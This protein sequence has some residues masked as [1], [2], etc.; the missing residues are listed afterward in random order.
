MDCQQRYDTLNIKSNYTL[1]NRVVVPAMASETATSEG[2]ATEATFAHYRRLSESGAG[3]IH[4]EY[5][6]VDLSGRSERHQLGASNDD[7]VPG[8]KTL[9]EIIKSS[10]AV[11]G[12][13]LVHGGGKTSKDLTG[14]ALLGPSAI[15]VPVKDREL[16]IPKSMSGA[17]ILD[18]Q[19]AF[20]AAAKRGVEA[21]FDLIELHAA[22][23]YGLNQWLSPLTNQR[24]DEYG[25][26]LHNRARLIIEI[27]QRLRQ[28]F[29][30]TILSAR[31]PGQDFIEGGLSVD[32]MLIITRLL[33][34]AGLD[35]VSVSSGLGGWRRP[36]DRDQEGYLVQE[37][38]RIQESTSKPVIGVGGIETGSYIDQAVCRRQL[39]LAAVGRAI[40]KDPGAWR[41]K[42]LTR[43]YH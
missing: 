42:N 22:H 34:D 40:L 7:H 12:L 36:R 33:I 14:G 15:R 43:A 29:P 3:L 10:G 4:V 31:I 27:V 11:A 32:D 13:Q 20:L 2:L 26:S 23:G 24:D 28:A 18:L 35:L 39:S 17:E 41:R 30:D 16:E 38:A 9:A 1:R 5:T 6:F 8:L 19:N 25:G 21:G 37:A